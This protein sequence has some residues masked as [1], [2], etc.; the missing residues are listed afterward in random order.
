M[1]QKLFMLTPFKSRWGTCVMQNW[2]SNFDPSNPKGML[3]PTWVT[4]RRVPYEFQRVARQ[5]AQGLGKVLGGD[6]HNS[7]LEDQKFCLALLAGDGWKT[8]V[9]VTN[10]ISRASSTIIVDYTDLPI[11]CRF[12][13]DTDHRVKGCPGLSNLKTKDNPSLT[14]ARPPTKAASAHSIPSQ[15]LPPPPPGLPPAGAKKITSKSQTPV[16]QAPTVETGATHPSVDT[17]PPTAG[18]TN[19]G[20]SSAKSAP[21]TATKKPGPEPGSKT[22]AATSLSSTPPDTNSHGAGPIL[23]KATSTSGFTEYVRL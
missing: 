16:L 7:T 18:H 14:G 8:S 13:L 9:T 11:R 19:V 10:A 5:I 2:I 4:L 17:T 21:L 12:C 3:V 22:I 1:V 6:R 23:P 15:G 20:T